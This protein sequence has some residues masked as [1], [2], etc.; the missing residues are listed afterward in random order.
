VMLGVLV[1]ADSLF[2]D[3]LAQPSRKVYRSNKHRRTLWGGR[4]ILEI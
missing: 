3:Q 4:C 2:P 1:G